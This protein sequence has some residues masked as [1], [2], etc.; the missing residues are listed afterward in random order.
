M[1]VLVVVAEG[2]LPVDIDLELQETT[3]L[4]LGRVGS[5]PDLV[6]SKDWF[7]ETFVQAGS[8]ESWVWS[9]VNGRSYE[10]REPTF[11]AFVYPDWPVDRHGV[12]LG[13]EV[14]Q[15][16]RAAVVRRGD[17]FQA[18]VGFGAKGMG[19][20]NIKVQESA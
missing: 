8:L 9:T 18:V 10:T 11:G 19:A 15:Q 5:E 16:R 13:L 3:R 6:T 4:W 12:L 2:M 17:Q 7:R 1:K 20:W 14:L